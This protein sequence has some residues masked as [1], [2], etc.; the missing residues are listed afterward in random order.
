M[1]LSTLTGLA[2]TEEVSSV[3]CYILGV[4]FY[5]Y[6]V[7]ILIFDRAIDNSLYLDGFI[8]LVN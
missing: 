7:V 3:G 4:R 8:F 5:S 2:E 1:P 6:S